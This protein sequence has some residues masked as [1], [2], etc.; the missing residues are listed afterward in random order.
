MDD[1]E[2]LCIELD[3]WDDSVGAF[4]PSKV[5]GQVCRAFPDAEIDQTDHQRVL[6]LRELEFWSQSVRES[7]MQEKLVRQSWG[8]YQRNGPSYKFVIPF[9]SGH[10][11]SGI[12]RR[13]SVGFTLPVGLPPEDRER[14]LTFLQSLQMGVPKLDDGREDE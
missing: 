10:R 1:L 8:T 14:L 3:Y 9:P 7:E 12:A 4:E 5:L 6:L 11:V 2:R 13:F